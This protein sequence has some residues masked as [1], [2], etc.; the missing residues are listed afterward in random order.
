MSYIWFSLN[1][2]KYFN[3]KFSCKRETITFSLRLYYL[4]KKGTCSTYCLFKTAKM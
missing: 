4:L 2:C 1:A 3:K